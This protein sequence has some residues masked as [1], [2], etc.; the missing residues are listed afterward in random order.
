MLSTK[1]QCNMTQ[2]ELDEKLKLHEMWLNDEGGERLDLS[3]KDLRGVEFSGANLISADLGEANLIGADLSGANNIFTFNRIG[4]RTCYAV[5]HEKTL[6]IKAGC[7][8]GTLDEFIKEAEEQGKYK[9]QIV[10]LIE[11]EKEMLGV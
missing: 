8:W 4:G 7:F 2:Q 6:M 3:G 10:Y 1:I 5:V 11:L 9:A